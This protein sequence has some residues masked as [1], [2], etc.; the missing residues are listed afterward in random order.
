MAEAIVNYQKKAKPLDVLFVNLPSYTPEP[1][2]SKNE[3]FGEN[4]VPPLGL[5]YLANSIKDCS[6]VSSY[7]CADFGIAKLNGYEGEKHLA[8]LV[9]KK[10]KETV[11]NKPDV[12]AVSLMFSLSYP[13]FQ[14]VIEEIRK[15]WKDTV[16]IVGG[17]HATNSADYL[18]KNNSVDYITCGEGEEAFPSLL[19]VVAT[20]VEKNILG[21]HSLGNI[22]KTADNKL[23]KTEAVEDFNIDFT[24]YSNLIDME[25]YTKGTIMFSLSKTDVSN[26]AFTIMAS[27]GCPY[28][29]TYCAS[30]TVQGRGS[31]WRDFKNIIDEIYWLNKN[32]GTIKYYL[33]DDVFVP[34]SK[35]L[36]FFALLAEVD[37]EGFE[38]VILNM[39]INATDTK[40]IDAIA[41]IGINTLTFAIE[42][43]SKVTQNKIKKWVNLDRAE[44]LCKYSQSKNLNVRAMYVIGF[45]GETISEM[46]ET[47]QYAEKLGANWSTFSVASPIPGSEM[48]DQFVELGYIEHGPSSWAGDTLRDRIFDTEEI[49]KEDIKDLAYRETLKSNFINNFDLEKSNFKNAETIMTNFLKSYDFHIFGYDCLRRIYKA[50]G[51]FEKES[52]TIQTMKALLLYNPKAREFRKYFDLLDDEILSHL[53]CGVGDQKI[54]K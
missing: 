45:P 40:I 19:E 53:K 1:A 49:S 54:L 50:S 44:E 31:R 2:N 17:V 47:F 21:V 3:T 18:L 43:G 14:I 29:C 8:V 23:E 48:T 27:R 13:F 51:N 30:H 42:S 39:S 52:K 36:E 11:T 16:I 37:I 24:Q 26:R 6:F 9:N 4:I 33:I 25:V 15:C 35:T 10:L 7:Q 22:K 46:E 20:G 41:S 28:L 32:Y 12:V 38:I 34:K 5:L